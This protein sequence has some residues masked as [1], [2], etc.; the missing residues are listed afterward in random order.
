MKIPSSPAAAPA[1]LPDARAGRRPASV[2]LHRLITSSTGAWVSS[3]AGIG[4]AAGSYVSALALRLETDLSAAPRRRAAPLLNPPDARGSARCFGFWMAGLLSGWWR[5]VSL[6]EVV[7]DIVRGNALGSLLFLLAIVF[8][9][10]LEGLSA[11][12]SS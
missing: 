1:L 8:G 12:A 5:H 4:I 9:P 11:L 6:Q 2:F 7:I 10:G 3:L